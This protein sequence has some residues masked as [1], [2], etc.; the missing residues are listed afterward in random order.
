[1]QRPQTKP[2]PAA[3]SKAQQLQQA[4]QAAQ[5]QSAAIGPNDTAVPCPQ[6]AANNADDPQQKQRIEVI[7]L[8]P[9]HNPLNAIAVVLS[10]PSGEQ[11]KSITAVNGRCAFEGL[12][13]GAYE[14]CLSELDQDCWQ[15]LKRTSLGE[16]AI[17]EGSASWQPAAA[18]K[19]SQG[20]PHEVKQGE[21][22]AKLAFNFGLAPD[23]IWNHPEN[24]KLKAD[25][26]ELH[27]L[28]PKD[29]VFIPP[30][31]L[32]KL[33][34]NS[35]ER[36]ELQQQ[37]AL[38]KLRIRFLHYDDTPR[39][40]LPFLVSIKT[41]KNDI[42][43][44]AQGKTDAAGFVIVDVPPN[45]TFAKIILGEG[46]EQEIH[47]F[48]L[49]FV[50]S[51]DTVSG[52]KARLNNLGFYCGEETEEMNDQTVGAIKA[53]QRRYELEVTGE[54]DDKTLKLLEDKFGS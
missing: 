39:T 22:I 12:E 28:N 45:A 37:S 33:P 8:G 47:E 17:S 51:I 14:V 42:W 1:M 53:F 40:D 4:E 36:I 50:D 9:Q 38:E 10:K 41:S 54:R 26:K 2:A 31:T 32:K 19:E 20:V 3:P 25:R 23:T 29:V 11:L 5:K 48:N 7:V 18:P 34:I 16:Q 52:V 35:G 24:E 27:I 30:K 15:L 49:G 21:C 46:E 43:P 44:D 13:H 6:Q